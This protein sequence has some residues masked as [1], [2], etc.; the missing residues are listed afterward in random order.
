[1]LA[2][3]FCYAG[4]WDAARDQALST[5][6]LEPAYVPA[7]WPLAR[8]YGGLGLHDKALDVCEQGLAHARDDTILLATSGWALAMLGRRTEAERVL[9]QLLHCRRSGY[10]SAVLIATVY[11]G[12]DRE[13]DVFTWLE[14]AY[15]DRDGLCATL[16][17]YFD[18]RIRDT[19]RFQALLRRMNFPETA[20]SPTA[21]IV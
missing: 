15:D 9:E 5:V 4:R 18:L 14:R 17:T 20:T 3:V 13:D 1:M 6:E 16:A 12:L 19:P 11:A 10:F 21:P 2:T 8:S 7:Y